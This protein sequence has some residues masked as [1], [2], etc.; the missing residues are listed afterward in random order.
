MV[1]VIAT[2]APLRAAGKTG[3]P[4]GPKHTRP[5]LIITAINFPVF[6]ITYSFA[7]VASKRDFALRQKLTGL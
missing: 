1:F 3:V 2:G 7:F 6:V 5:K 4:S